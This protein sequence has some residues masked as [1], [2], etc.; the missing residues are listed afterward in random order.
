MLLLEDMG[1]NIPV[2]GVEIPSYELMVRRFPKQHRLLPLLLAAHH[3]QTIR[4]ITEDIMYFG[5]RA[6]T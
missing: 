2:P 5:C 6:Y 1:V 4:A 3:K